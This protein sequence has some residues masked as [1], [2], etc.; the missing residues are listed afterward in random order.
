MEMRAFLGGSDSKE[1]ACHA[2]DSGLIP[3]SGRSAG[4]ENSY[5]SMLAWRIPQ[6]RNLV[7]QSPWGHKESDTTEQLTHTNTHNET[8]FTDEETEGMKG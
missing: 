2:G 6:Y 8:H 7:G 5:S 1:S 3:W 4:E